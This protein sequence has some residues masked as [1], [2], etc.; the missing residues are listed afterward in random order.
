MRNHL[1]QCLR[2]PDAVKTKAATAQAVA[3]ANRSPARWRQTQ[4]PQVPIWP[5]QLMVPPP[6][7]GIQFA[8]TSAVQ[9]PPQI[10]AEQ[11]PSQSLLFAGP[12]GQA[13]SVSP[14]PSPVFSPAPWPISQP[15]P[16]A[17]PSTGLFD[18]QLS[19]PPSVQVFPADLPPVK[20]RRMSSQ[21]PSITSLSRYVSPA[22]SIVD[23]VPG[24]R[25]PLPPLHFG[26]W[27][28]LHQHRLYMRLIRATVSAGIPFSWIENSEVLLLFQEFFHPKAVIPSRHSL[29]RTIL[30]AALDELRAARDEALRRAKDPMGTLQF[31]GWTALNHHHY[32]AFMLYVIRKV[33]TMEMPRS[34]ASMMLSTGLLN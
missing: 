25:S 2:Q 8:S 24:V 11:M 6:I 17:T 28:P 15:P 33:R 7:P 12:S 4:A 5:L 19:L 18:R 23:D 22:P 3:A 10:G 20:R 34:D 16:S 21:A 29:T 14:T 1:A 27:T 9:L 32:D 13:L 26:L 31:D 30:P